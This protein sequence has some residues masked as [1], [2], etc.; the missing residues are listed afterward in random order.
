MGLTGHILS[1]RIKTFLEDDLGIVTTVQ[2]ENRR[3]ISIKD[4]HSMRHVFCYYAGK[5]GIPISVVQSIVGHMDE[6][7]TAYYQNH[8]QEETQHQELEKLPSVL[9]LDA[10]YAKF[11]I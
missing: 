5:V 1:K 6:R 8:V 9:L 10:E 4:L 3:S 2:P 11:A 7:M